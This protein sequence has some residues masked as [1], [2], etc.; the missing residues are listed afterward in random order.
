MAN[1]LWSFS[2]IPLKWIRL[3]SWGLQLRGWKCTRKTWLFKSKLCGT[4]SWGSHSVTVVTLADSVNLLYLH[5]FSQDLHLSINPQGYSNIIIKY[6][7]KDATEGRFYI[8]HCLDIVP[9]THPK[10][11]NYM[12]TYKNRPVFPCDGKFPSDIRALIYIPDRLPTHKNL[13][14]LQLVEWCKI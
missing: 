5:L 13:Q 8:G 1:R 7:V 6:Y 2:A 3:I 10:S 14:P 12:G 9:G 4:T 11:F